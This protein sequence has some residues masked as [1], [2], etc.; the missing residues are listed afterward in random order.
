MRDIWNEI[1]E[2]YAA[3]ETFGIATVTGTFGSAPR[4]PGASMAVSRSGEVVG[5]VSG[6]CVE[7]AV[8]DLAQRVIETGVPRVETYGIADED[9]FA[10]GLTCGGRLQVLVQPMGGD[11]FPEFAEVA[12]AVDKDVPVA[13]ATGIGVAFTSPVRRL[14]WPAGALGSLGAPELDA[15]VDDD[16]RGLLAQGVSGT[17]EYGPRGERA[18][19]ERTVFVH[20]LAAPPR[21]L[22][23]GAIDFAA[24]ATR[25]GRFLGYRVTVCDARARFATDKRFPDAD[26]VV[27]DWPHRYLARTEVDD[28]TV[29]CVLT[30]DAKFDV[31]LL[32]LALRT[33]AG[34]VGAM[35]SRS[36]HVER[37]TQLRKAGL[38]ERELGRLHSPIGLDLGARTPEET[39]V[40]IAAELVQHRWGGTGRSLMTTAGPIHRAAAGH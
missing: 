22:I 12:A 13:I 16:A 4:Q 14:V 39:A 31:P 20:S 6:G 3:G 25:I 32:T 10:T 37:L 11:Y 1:V 40:S 33:R 26:E 23:F 35:G 19:T 8:Y 5:S 34:Y 28:R 2:W 7:S 21:M 18:L 9:A 38:T 24:A 29:I 36:A 27:V 15:A 30:H 17:R